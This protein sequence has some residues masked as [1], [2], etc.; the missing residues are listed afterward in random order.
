MVDDESFVEI[1]GSIFAWDIRARENGTCFPQ[2]PDLS[3]LNE[4]L[5]ND[6]LIQ[7]ILA[8]PL[9][10]ESIF[11]VAKEHC[12]NDNPHAWASVRLQDALDAGLIAKYPDGRYGAQV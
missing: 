5:F 4:E 2:C 11:A 6:P 10:G 7:A 1:L 8:E 3:L 12:G 9:D